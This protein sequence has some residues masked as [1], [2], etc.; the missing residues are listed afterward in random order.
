MKTEKV[1][2]HE[3]LDNLFLV[4][5][6]QDLEGFRQF[7]SS[8]I[9][10][11]AGQIIIIDPG[12]SSTIPILLKALHEL[13]ISRIDYILLTHIH[14]DH[15]GGTGLLV[16]R[17]PQVKV[18]CHPKGIPHMIDP[19]KL[20][21]GSR[22]VLGKIAEAYGLVTPVSPANISWQQRMMIN[23]TEIKAIE[24]PGHASH[25]VCYSAGD[26][27]FAGEVAGVNVPLADGDYLRI[28]TPPLF[29]YE[30]YKR[31]LFRASKIEARYLCFGHYGMRR[32]LK[33]VFNRAFEQLEI[34][35][36]II[37][38]QIKN[39]SIGKEDS[40]LEEL[41]ERDRSI[42]HFSRLPADIQKREKFFCLNSI[43]G[44]SGYQERKKSK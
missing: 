32:D 35:M 38:K 14:I 34:W 4:D 10:R 8:W 26:L 42:S 21:E 13:K 12:P 23:G 37:K 33:Q 17:Y 9:Y 31:S 3:I 22:Q 1:R 43:R 20:W 11:L 5:L 36:R 2:I 30:I 44:I 40:V 24:T 29:D 41:L 28:A 39:N 7:V 27:L 25:H 18:N 15:A 19:Q 6:D 16:T